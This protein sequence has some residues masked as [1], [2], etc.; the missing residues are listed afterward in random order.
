MKTIN[1]NELNLDNLAVW[2]GFI[3]IGLII[4]CCLILF[5]LG[6]W[7]DIR[8]QLANLNKVT[9]QENELR[10][11]FQTKAEQAVNLPLYQQ[12]IKQ[13]KQILAIMVKQLPDNTE[14]PNLLEEISKIGTANGLE[15]HLFKPLPEKFQDFFDE[16]PIQI[17]VVGDYHQLGSFIA[18]VAAL[19]RI[20]TLHDFNIDIYKDKHARAS[21]KLA[22]AND[23]AVLQMDI[24]AKTYRYPEKKRSNSNANAA[25]NGANVNSAAR[26]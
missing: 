4:T 12:Q 23:G 9:Q 6:Y 15:F 14:I 2:P 16:V 18:Q 17:S 25:N 24:I 3:K 13:M 21:H 19:N 1:L 10:K 11:E 26:Q 22:A 8:L 5:F 20:V 7:F